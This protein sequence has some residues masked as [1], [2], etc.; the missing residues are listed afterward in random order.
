[1]PSKTL[2]KSFTVRAIG[3]ICATGAG[4]PSH[5]P[6]RL[7][8]PGVGRSETTAFHAPGRRIDARVSSPRATVVKFAARAAPEPPED[9]PTVR[10]RSYGLRVTPNIEP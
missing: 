9:P 7:T 8:R 3:P 4:Y 5:M 2:A 10:S 1:M 6:L